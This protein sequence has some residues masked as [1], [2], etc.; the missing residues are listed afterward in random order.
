MKASSKSSAHTRFIPRE[1]I[2]GCSA[3][4]FSAMDGSEDAPAVTQASAPV[5]DSPSAAAAL[6]DARE[7]IDLVVCRQEGGAALSQLLYQIIKQQQG[8]KTE[9]NQ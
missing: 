4:R 7:Q 6:H 3:W 5:T 8:S 1:E 2:D 9:M